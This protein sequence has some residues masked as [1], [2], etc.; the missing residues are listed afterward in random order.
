M[1]PSKTALW[2][3]EHGAELRT[4]LLATVPKYFPEGVHDDPEDIV[5]DFFASL[6][7]ND[8]LDPYVD[9]S[10]EEDG[11]HYHSRITRGKLT[12]WC[13]RK[14]YQRWR[15]M[16]N[17]ISTRCFHG[18]TTEMAAYINV[19]SLLPEHD[20]PDNNDVNRDV[21]LDNKEIGRLVD[22]AIAHC[23][24]RSV[25]RTTKL[26]ILTME[27]YRNRE[28][29]RELGVSYKRMVGMTLLMRKQLSAHMRA[30]PRKFVLWA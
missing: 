21:R 13:L 8:S 18:T 15:R 19:V 7:S 17:D 25:N 1:A 26:L 24:P 9:V 2:L 22:E 11:E 12:G 30:R 16:G 3:N 4:H 10:L 5:Q 14:G 20:M 29:A 28:K 23:F 6:L 27:G